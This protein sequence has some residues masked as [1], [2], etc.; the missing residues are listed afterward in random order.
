MDIIGDIPNDIDVFVNCKK[1]K[2]LKIISRI[3]AKNLDNYTKDDID[4]IKKILYQDWYDSDK[5][6]LTSFFINKKNIEVYVCKIHFDGIEVSF[7]VNLPKLWN[8]QLNIDILRA[9]NIYYTH[10]LL[11]GGISTNENCSKFDIHTHYPSLAINFIS[12]KPQ[13][14]I[15]RKNI[16][17]ISEFTRK[18]FA[19]IPEM[20]CAEICK[21]VDTHLTK[22]NLRHDPQINSLIWQY[23]SKDFSFIS[24]TNSAH[25]LAWQFIDLLGLNSISVNPL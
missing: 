20:V 4:K 12:N 23:L 22:Y 2:F 14:S 7:I 11:I 24:D 8:P 3:Q 19:K 16:T 5:T 1:N 17:H 15:D 25:V 13:L 9:N 21:I 18:A 6:S 10:H